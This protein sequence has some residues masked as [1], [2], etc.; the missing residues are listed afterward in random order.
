VFGG[1]ECSLGA[2]R[3]KAGLELSHESHLLQHEAAGGA[4]DLRQIREANV[5][6]VVDI[7]HRRPL[8]VRGTTT[9]AAGRGK[10]ASS[11]PA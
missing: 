10:T 4:L 6:A 9:A 5:E 3:D 2:I 11:H 8:A 1:G 7:N